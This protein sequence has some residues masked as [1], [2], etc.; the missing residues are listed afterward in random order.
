MPGPE[1]DLTVFTLTEPE[2][3]LMIPIGAALIIFHSLVHA[4]IDAEYLVRNK[5]P[6]ERARSGH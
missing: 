3:I 2:V 5:L 1:L 4:A 6:P